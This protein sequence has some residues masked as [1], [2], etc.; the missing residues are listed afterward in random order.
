M[1]WLASAVLEN[2]HHTRTIA[3]CLLLVVFFLP[4]QLY[5]ALNCEENQLYELSISNTE[6]LPQYAYNQ[7]MQIYSSYY[8]FGN[9]KRNIA[10]WEKTDEYAG[11]NS[12]SY[13]NEEI[14]L[15]QSPDAYFMIPYTIIGGEP[16]VQIPDSALRVENYL[17]IPVASD[18]F[19][20]NHTVITDAT[21]E[22]N[23]DGLSILAAKADGMSYAA[24][25]VYNGRK[26]VTVFNIKKMQYEGILTPESNPGK[27]LQ[28]ELYLIDIAA[29]TKSDHF[30]FE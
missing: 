12:L 30:I 9:L 28:G 13:I 6:Y 27:K 17:Y 10:L 21:V 29:L 3:V 16:S 14:I 19:T 1:I 25:L 2:K 22:L 18:I 7:K 20:D 15:E 24:A 26:L 5:T 8:D 23:E 11:I 4:S